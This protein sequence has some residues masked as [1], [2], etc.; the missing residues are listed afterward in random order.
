MGMCPG[1]RLLEG[2]CVAFT[3]LILSFISPAAAT[4]AKG[5][6][7]RFTGTYGADDGVC[8]NPV[9]SPAAADFVV[10]GGGTSGCVVAA[11][12]CEALPQASLRR[13]PIGPPGAGAAPERDPG[14]AG[15]VA[16]AGERCVGGPG[17][18]TGS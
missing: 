6:G 11:R 9:G 8:G 15:A 4:A 3:L 13:R 18:H 1:R 2:A 5:S 14:A 10:I 17:H 7:C 16:A 12:L